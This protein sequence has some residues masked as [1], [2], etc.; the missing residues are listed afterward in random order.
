MV[1]GWV[2]CTESR[3]EPGLRRLAPQ[4]GVFAG[5]RRGCAITFA[6]VYYAHYLKV[7]SVVLLTTG[8]E[9]PPRH[10]AR[11]GNARGH[12]GCRIVVR[13]VCGRVGC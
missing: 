10:K 1:S 2:L 12:A 9:C 13:V 5:E 7:M 11:D 8:K 6:V 4:L 3:W